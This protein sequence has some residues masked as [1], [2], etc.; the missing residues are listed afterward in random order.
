MSIREKFSANRTRNLLIGAIVFGLVAA[1][2]SVAYLKSREAAIREALLRSQQREIAVVVAS[3]DLTPGAAIESRNLAVRQIPQEYVHPDALAPNEFER[4]EGRVLVEPVASGKPVLKS[5]IEKQF[6]TTFS[7]TIELKRRAI[8]VQV[9]DVNSIS[10]LIR[11]GDRVDLFANMPAESLNPGQSADDEGVGTQGKRIVPVLQNIEVL[12]TGEEAESD[13]REK[14]LL[15]E[16]G[17][18]RQPNV[19]YTTLTVSVTPEQGAYLSTARDVGDLIAMLRNRRDQGTAMFTSLGSGEL[20][21]YAGAMA[22]E[23]RIRAQ[24]ESVENSGLQEITADDVTVREDGTVVTKDGRVLEGVTMNEDGQLV[25]ADGE[26]VDSVVATRDGRVLDGKNLSVNENGELVT[27][28]GTVLSGRNLSV[29]ENGELVTADGR[30]VDP[31]EV[32]VTESGRLLTADG[33]VLDNRGDGVVVTRDGRVMTEDGQV[34]EGVSVNE[35]GDLVTADGTVVSGRDLRVD[36][37]GRVVTADGRV[38][39][40]VSAQAVQQIAGVGPGEPVRIDYIVGGS[41]ENGVAKVVV[42]PVLE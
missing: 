23:A 20:L 17:V 30:V 9:D 36:E 13:Y 21:E 8:T 4:F 24:A 34:L 40:G 33:E 25:N 18:A 16:G 6:P 7:D 27:E 1:I 38:L 19:T 11:P 42:L 35:N 39:E 26:V 12:A 28:D 15:L 2:L 41:G 14:L 5:F 31:D 32:Q 10:G 3:R 37:N 29:N 22:E